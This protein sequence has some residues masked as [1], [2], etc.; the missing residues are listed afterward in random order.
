[1]QR[2]E[3]INEDTRKDARMQ[4]KLKEFSPALNKWKKKMLPAI[5]FPTSNRKFENVASFLPR[6][7][8]LS[9]FFLEYWQLE[10]KQ[11]KIKLMA[12]Q[13]N[14]RSLEDCRINIKTVLFDNVVYHLH[15]HILM[16]PR[17]YKKVNPKT[18]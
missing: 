13:S 15:R 12:R 5:F 2:N 17:K 7:W 8:D 6:W 3:D 11:L 16:R 9:D 1:M 4:S 10:E 14:L 18:V